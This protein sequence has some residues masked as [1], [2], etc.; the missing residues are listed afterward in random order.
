L[1]NDGKRSIQHSTS[2]AEGK[3][4]EIVLEMDAMSAGY[5]LSINGSI[6]GNGNQFA[7]KS[8]PERIEFRTGAYRLN[9]K[10][11]ENKSGNES[12]PGWDEPEAG[13]PVEKAIFYI[14]N[15]ST[16]IL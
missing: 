10:I 16:E 15:L 7:A 2:L 6:H 9:R 5:D 8:R 3:W 4:N 13:Q 1:F 11:L 14:R 12:I